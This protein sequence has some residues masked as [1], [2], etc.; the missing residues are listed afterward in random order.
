MDNKNK[1][2][3]SKKTSS[4]P[5][6]NFNK[7]FDIPEM[8]KIKSDKVQYN[9]FERARDLVSDL[10][11][12]DW[13]K[14][15]TADDIFNMLNQI[16]L[17]KNWKNN[18]YLNKF[19][20]WLDNK[21][22]SWRTKNEIFYILKRVYKKF[23][24]HWKKT[25][26]W[27]FVNRWDLDWAS[28][29]LLLQLSGFKNWKL[30]DN[31][32]FVEN[33]NIGDWVTL[34]S[35][36]IGWIKVL[37][38]E[39]VDWQWKRYKTLFNSK[40]I[41]D[42]HNWWPCSTTR[43]VY[44]M[45]KKLWRI[46]YDKQDQIK[47][48]VEFVD[49]ADDLLYQASWIIS[50]YLERTIFGLH[51]M[52]P[53]NLIFDYFKDPNKT[54]FEYLED[55]FLLK[56]KISFVDHK[57]WEKKDKTLKDIS[58][59]KKERMEMSYKQIFEAEKNWQ[60]L[61]KNGRRFIVDIWWKIIDAQE[62]VQAYDY[63]LIRVFPKT[64]DL[65]IY[66]PHKL[67]SSIWW[68]EI[69]NDH[70][71]IDKW[72]SWKDIKSLLNEFEVYKGKKFKESFD[73]GSA[74]DIKNKIIEARKSFNTKTNQEKDKVKQDF[75]SLPNLNKSDLSV[76]NVY[77]WI[78]NNIIGNIIFVTLD[79]WDSIRWFLHKSRLWDKKISE[80]DVWQK[81]SVKLDSKEIENNS[82]KIQLSFNGLPKEYQA[83]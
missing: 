70:F 12:S 78:V 64:W 62:A 1:S 9:S 51:K 52:L 60:F 69:K 74:P 14:Q 42:E 48:F 81:I 44:Q 31:V 37:P 77:N 41:L 29:L 28:S 27:D 11:K 79:S 54:W 35:G 47:R 20:R 18:T 2:K 10:S 33:E 83:A 21:L 75:S 40:T 5:N 22:E 43:I 24:V 7:P 73:R 32:W 66:S 16:A 3:F 59:E 68:F 76:W 67:A 80:F 25:N 58:N 56:N 57:S 8:E 71:I 19:N 30:W 45:L 72:K 61:I 15:D 36:N 26:S 6:S 82:L 39:N 55:D 53:V 63:G 17:K 23:T 46:P 49:I 13:K 34:D 38:K 4:K 65:Y 50:P